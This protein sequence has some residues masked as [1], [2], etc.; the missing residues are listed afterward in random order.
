[1]TK[2]NGLHSYNSN[3]AQQSYNRDYKVM[4]NLR[5][6]QN[7]FRSYSR[8]AFAVFDPAIYRSF[9]PGAENG[10]LHIT[11]NKIHPLL[12]RTEGNIHILSDYW[13]FILILI[14]QDIKQYV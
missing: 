13:A 10:D 11:G 5:I 9:I 2:E 4:G 6:T 12:T 14:V 8:L 7:Y 3:C 1:M